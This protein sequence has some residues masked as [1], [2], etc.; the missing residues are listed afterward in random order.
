MEWPLATSVSGDANDWLI[1]ARSLSGRG[2]LD[3]ADNDLTDAELAAVTAAILWG[4]RDGQVSARSAAR[5]AAHGAGE[6]R[7][8]LKV[9][10]K[11]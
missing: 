1:V 2:P 6:V 9:P 11:G 8:G 10:L 3:H 5:S 7:R 4:R